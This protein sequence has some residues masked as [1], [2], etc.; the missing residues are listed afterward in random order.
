MRTKYIVIWF[1]VIREINKKKGVKQMFN[2]T[3]YTIIYIYIYSI[4]INGNIH[5]HTIYNILCIYKYNPIEAE[6]LIYW[7]H[8][9]TNRS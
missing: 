6:Q 4:H 2:G 5:T 7:I 9:D 1:M 3:L 8:V